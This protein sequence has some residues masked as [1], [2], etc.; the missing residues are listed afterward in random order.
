[1]FSQKFLKNPVLIMGILLMIVFLLDLKNRGSDS[2]LGWLV[3]ENYDTYACK[4][5][6]VKLVKH[7]PSNW[8]VDCEKNNM[9]VLIDEMNTSITNS[10]DRQKIKTYAY[11]QLANAFKSIAHHSAHEPLERVDIVRIRYTLGKLILNAVS[12]GK[13]LFKLYSIKSQDQIA[14]HLQ[15]TVQVQEKWK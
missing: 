2:T 8:K 12:E 11:R 10:G 5:A 3:K 4:G 14:G 7:T 15:T 6:I 1:M 13:D 9:A